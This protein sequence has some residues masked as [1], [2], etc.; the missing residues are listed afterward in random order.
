MIKLALTIS[1]IIISRV[2]D[3]FVILSRDALNK[4]IIFNIEKLK[5]YK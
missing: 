2:T 4:V 5:P 1:A 3:S